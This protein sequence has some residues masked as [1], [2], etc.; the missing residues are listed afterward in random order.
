[1][2]LCE[3]LS[4]RLSCIL[5]GSASVAALRRW[6][7]PARC[8]GRNQA[9]RHHPRPA[10]ACSER[11]G[12]LDEM[13]LCFPGSACAKL[14]YLLVGCRSGCKPY[15]QHPQISFAKELLLEQQ[16]VPLAE[17]YAMKM[18]FQY[19]EGAIDFCSDS[20]MCVRRLR[21][22]GRQSCETL[23]RLANPSI[24]LSIKLLCQDRPACRATWIRSHQRPDAADEQWQYVAN[25][26]ADRVAGAVA[27][28]LAH[29]WRLHRRVAVLACVDGPMSQGS[30][31]ADAAIWL[32]ARNHAQTG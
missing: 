21:K 26:E 20:Q 29:T 14:P 19:T 6:L 5:T 22:V 18:L 30:R 7:D 10:T 31:N 3:V 25:Q 1:M 4:I 28:Q 27:A 8:H 15:A 12:C 9:C 2:V 32:L 16:T 11:K 24:W 13:E 17:A 23:E